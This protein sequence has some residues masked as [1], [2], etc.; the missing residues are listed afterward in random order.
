[1]IAATC[2]SAQTLSY[3]TRKKRSLTLTVKDDVREND[4]KIGKSVPT[5]RTVI[6]R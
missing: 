6:S 1:M 3:G 5:Y 4:Q 2:G